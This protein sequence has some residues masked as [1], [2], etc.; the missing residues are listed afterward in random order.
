MS[1]GRR[2]AG[3]RR[4][5]VRRWPG[6]PTSISGTIAA[7][8]AVSGNVAY[9]ASFAYQ[10]PQYFLT[11]GN[12]PWGNR[13]WTY[14]KTGNRLT[15]AETGDATQTYTYVQNGSS[16][17]TSRLDRITPAP[18]YGTGFLR[19]PTTRT[20]QCADMFRLVLKGTRP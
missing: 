4:K 15:H 8:G 16:K 17:N 18:G 7:I 20:S 2:A 13:T 1:K 6:S 14:D 9:S 10:D 12:G 11:Q 3:E 5:C 19:S